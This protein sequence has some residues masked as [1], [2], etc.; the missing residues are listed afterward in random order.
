MPPRA[1]REPLREE[2]G[3]TLIEL[4]IVVGI[5]GLLVAIAV[6]GLL[7]SR[8]SANEAN[9]I[10][11]IRAILAA[12]HTYASSSGG[13]YATA[14]ATL[15]IPCPGSSVAFISPDL[16]SDPSV[17][18]GY[19]IALRPA[20]G[21]AGGAPDCNG[22]PTHVNFYVSATPLSLGLDGHRGFAAGAGGA[23]FY[24]ASGGAPNEGQMAS[25]AAPVVQ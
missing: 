22:S 6:P 25:G 4:L 7:R 5:I 24:D 17:K 15:A 3:F 14:L 16:A 13:G 12:E 10:A 1:R 19:R 9:A 23:I 8:I 18:A 2:R 20:S 21:A 11:S